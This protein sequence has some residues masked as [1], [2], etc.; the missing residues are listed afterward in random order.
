MFIRLVY[1]KILMICVIALLALGLR[2]L[3]ANAQ[4]PTWLEPVLLSAPPEDKSG[5]FPDVVVDAT[6]RIHVVWASGVKLGDG[7]WFDAVMYTTS[8]DG[9]SWS[10]KV[11]IAAPELGS[12]E[13]TRP[14]L[15]PDSQGVLHIT[16]RGYNVYYSHAPTVAASSPARWLA[17]SRMNLDQPAYFSRVTRD[18]QGRLHLIFT[19]NVITPQC[20]I[21]Y[22]IFHRW[23]SN[24]GLTWSIITEVSTIPSGAIKPQI[25]VDELDNLHVVWEAGIGGT[26]GQLSGPS[27]I[28]YSASYDGGITWSYPLEFSAS[29]S[30]GKNITLGLDGKG[31]LIAAW[32]SVAE[33]LI[34]Y[35]FSSD[36]GHSWSP[37]RTIPRVW[38]G[39]SIFN[40]G[41]DDYTM[42]TDS[43]GNVHLVLVG[44]LDPKQVG[45]LNIVHLIWDGVA[46]SSPQIVATFYGDAPEW[47]RLAIGNGNQLHAVWFVRDEEHIWESGKQ[48][49]QIWYARGQTDAPEI[50]PVTLEPTAT[51]TVTSTPTAAP[52]HTPTPTLTPTIDPNLTRISSASGV[53]ASIYSETD[54]LILLIQSLLPTLLVVAFIVFGVRYWRR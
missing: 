54:E 40:T 20:P 44:I 1:P 42:A 14:T 25:I 7:R 41:L 27:K 33:N 5:W 50:P 9:K 28:M 16:Y 35:Q 8:Q 22:H 29:G 37:P 53:A 43:A 47:P 30:E 23:S 39:Y 38:G 46:W 15:Y 19:E 31:K 26:L 24:N 6:G 32:L 13:A 17:P 4:D 18:S 11:D 36:H 49:Y 51:P 48:Q 21:C 2:T 52:T 10:E 45:S 3:K 12:G 34:Y